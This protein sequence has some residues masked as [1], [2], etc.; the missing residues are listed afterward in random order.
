MTGRRSPALA[1]LATAVVLAGPRP[2]HAASPREQEALTRYDEGDRRCDGPRPP[3]RDADA[4]CRD[5]RAA[6]QAYRASA[7]AYIDAARDADD[8]PLALRRL[9]GRA[10]DALSAAVKVG[11]GE[12]DVRAVCRALR[13]TADERGAEV[14][15]DPGHARLDAL[16]PAPPSPAPPPPAAIS[17]HSPPIARSPPERSLPAPLLS[18]DPRPRGPRDG[19]A[20]VA[21]GLALGGAGVA[22]IGA[23]AISLAIDREKV[24]EAN[25]MLGPTADLEASAAYFKR[26]NDVRSAE[27][28]LLAAGAGLLVTIPAA[29]AA[30]IRGASIAAGFMATLGAGVSVAG[31][32][33]Y[34]RADRAAGRLFDAAPASPDERRD[35]AFY[36]GPRRSQLSAAAALGVGAGVLVGSA[37]TLA[38]RRGLHR[39][40]RRYVLTPQLGATGL[41]LRLT[42]RF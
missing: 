25:G 5:P 9:L 33:L 7:L 39:R 19:R 2:A 3:A 37:V 38:V 41:G 32:I 30:D 17:P 11:T 24:R 18:Q 10:I 4:P 15:A 35:E 21:L 1:A 31:T 6:S 40:H 36:A 13:I 26:A 34:V 20:R 42:G 14:A 12:D 8:D 22:L 23:G 16:C 28:G 27:V 29:A